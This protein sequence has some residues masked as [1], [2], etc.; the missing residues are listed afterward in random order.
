MRVV[1]TLTIAAVLA[2]ATVNAAQAQ[3]LLHMAAP[4]DSAAPVSQPTFDDKIQT[5]T[6]LPPKT[7]ALVFLNR[8]RQKAL[9][10]VTGGGRSP[11]RRAA[12]K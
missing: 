12:A 7:G 2:L 11:A 5:R 8:T 1:H 3:R 6:A 9:L 10:A 4:T